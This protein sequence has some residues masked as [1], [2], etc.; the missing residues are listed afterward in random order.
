M[1]V[2]VVRDQVHLEH[3]WVEQVGELAG[4]FD[5]VVHAAQHH[6]L[7]E[8]LA[9]AERKVT[10]TLGKHLG[11]RIPIVDRHQLAP[12]LIGGCVQRQRE[13]DRLLDVVYEPS[14][15]REPA[16]GGD[17]RTSPGDAEVGQCARGF[18][19][20]VEVEHGLAHPHE[21][22][23]VDGLDASEVQGLV[24]D[25]RRGEVPAEAHVSGRAERAGKWTARLRR[26][27]ERAS[28]I[29]VAHEHGFDRVALMRTEKRL[30]RPVARLRLV[31]ELQGRERHD[32]RQYL[33]QGGGK[34]RHVVVPGRATGR[35]VP[36]L[37][38]AVRRLAALGQAPFELRAIHVARVASLIALLPEG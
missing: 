11:E 25:L 36:H 27:A 24:D 35:P 5:P 30:H 19:H 26:E 7:D 34:I 20:R 33:S 38:S 32:L 9:P 4:L 2:G 37:S 1:P 29:A 8:D 28:P 17:G 10:V 6:V 31:R 23:M 13:P 12:Q 3:F 22:G 14:Q 21:H 16:D 15:S 18:E